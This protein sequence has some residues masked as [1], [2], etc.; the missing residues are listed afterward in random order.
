MSGQTDVTG[1][2][3]APASP[4]GPAVIGAPVR[5]RPAGPAGEPTGPPPGPPQPRPAARPAS[6]TPFVL[7][8]VALLGGGLLCLLLI[9]TILATGAVQITKLQQ[10]NVVLA[11]Q[12]QPLQAQIASEESPSGLAWRARKLGMTEPS[13][14]HFLDLRKGRIDNEPTHLPDVHVVPPGYAP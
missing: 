1:I 13:L 5:G 12:T 11:Q 14:L 7:L 4:R 3:R 8:V 9:N 10:E 6:R 2:R